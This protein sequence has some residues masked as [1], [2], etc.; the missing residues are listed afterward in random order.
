MSSIV[1]K[2][3]FYGDIHTKAVLISQLEGALA[4]MKTKEGNLFSF[5]F[6]GLYI[7][8]DRNTSAISVIA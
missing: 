2:G 1:Y 8:I 3:D 7:E 5:I 4:D 6:A